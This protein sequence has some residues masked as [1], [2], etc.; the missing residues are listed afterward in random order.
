MDARTL[1][2][3]FVISLFIGLRVLWPILSGL[4]MLMAALGSVIGWLEGWRVSEAIYF[5]L[6][7]SLTVGYGD[8]VPSML[9]TRLLAILIGICGVIFSALLAA[10]AVKAFVVN[11][12][13]GES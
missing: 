4:L 5:T 1:R 11:K 12:P 13:G 3:N 6:V 10:V 7:T 2:R 8:L 9:S